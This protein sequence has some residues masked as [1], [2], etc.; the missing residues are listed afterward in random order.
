MI[1]SIFSYYDKLITTIPAGYAAL[2]SLA[3]LALLVWALYRFV[4]GNFIWIILIV[5]FI[6]ATWPALKS[7]GRALAYIAGFFLARIK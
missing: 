7:I 4:K 2:L 3:I 1:N 6:P 5:V